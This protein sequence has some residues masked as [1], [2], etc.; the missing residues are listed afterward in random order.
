MAEPIPGITGSTDAHVAE[1]QEGVIQTAGQNYETYQDAVEDRQSADDTLESESKKL[2]RRME[3][4]GKFKA[5]FEIV[6]GILY[7]LTLGPPEYTPKTA[8]EARQAVEMLEKY[9]A[10][11]AAYKLVA[12]DLYSIASDQAADA[13]MR[14]EKVDE[15]TQAQDI[16]ALHAENANLKAQQ[17]FRE[18]EETYK[19][20]AV[21]DAKASGINI[22]YPGYMRPRQQPQAEQPPVPSQT[23]VAPPTPES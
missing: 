12:A 6:D 4:E 8:E 2:Q 5:T 10:K 21:A 16:K 20:D 15:L 3:S 11:V 19:A 7:D 9:E 18:N 1:S 22:Q 14:T 23:D 17:H 13:T